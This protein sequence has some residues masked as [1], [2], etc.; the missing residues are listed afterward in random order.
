MKKFDLKSFA[1][2]P[3]DEHLDED[4]VSDF[5]YLRK[6]WTTIREDT[7]KSKAPVLIT[8]LDTPLIKVA[9]DLNQRTIE[10]IIFS[11]LKTMKS[12]KKLILFSL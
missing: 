9:R 4:I 11:D 3:S 7:L 1:K 6:L 8:E 5:N 2:S 10:E 12:Y